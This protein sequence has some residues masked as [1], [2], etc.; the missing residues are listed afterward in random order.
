MQFVG[1]VGLPAVIATLSAIL[2]VFSTFRSRMR[3]RG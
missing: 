3:R 1:P 2:I